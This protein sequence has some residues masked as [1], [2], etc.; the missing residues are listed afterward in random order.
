[1]I[2]DALK[3]T[4]KYEVWNERKQNRYHRGL[5]GIEGVE[6]SPLI[7]DVHDDAK[8]DDPRRGD[9]SLPEA[10]QRP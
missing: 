7:D 8:D 10:P 5:D 4:A 9:D 1:M 3:R 2:R 6:H